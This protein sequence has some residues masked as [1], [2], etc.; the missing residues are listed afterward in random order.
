MR[1][2]P[3]AR[4]A[5]SSSVDLLLPCSTRRSAGTPADRAT[6]SSPPGRDVEPHALLVGQP[7]HRQAQEGLGGVGDAVAPGRDRLAAARP[8]VVLVVDEQRRAELLGQLEDVDAADVEVALLVHERAARQEVA[9]QGCGRDVVV[10]RHGDAGYGSLRALHAR[11]DRRR[12]LGTTIVPCSCVGAGTARP[13][14]SADRAP[15]SGAGGAG[16]SP[17]GGAI[18]GGAESCR[19]AMPGAPCAGGAKGLSRRD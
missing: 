10:R 7:G 18:A 9:L 15:A 8:E 2:T 17:A 13:R 16:S 5:A 1:P 12:C 14:S 19:G 11:R 3:A 6:W 4:A